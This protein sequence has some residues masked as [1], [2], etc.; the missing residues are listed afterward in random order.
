MS[1]ATVKERGVLF[2][3][4]MVRAVLEGRK[5]QTRRIVKDLSYVDDEGN[6]IQ[7]PTPDQWYPEALQYC[8]YGYIGDR[9]WVRET[10]CQ[11]VDPDTSRPY[12]PPRAHY[13]SDGNEV[14]LDDGDG[15]TAYREDG[16]ECSPWKA[17]IHMP[18][19]ASRILLEVTAVGVERV[20]DISERDAVAEGIGRSGVG[21]KN[22]G[23]DPQVMFCNPVNS[24]ISLW[25]S[26]NAAK[27]YGWDA[28]PWVWV[29]EFKVL[30]VKR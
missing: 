10:W 7:R 6:T 12:D 20:Q 19:W 3:G 16:T 27:G 22:Y 1:A 23:V 28:N 13:R 29:V 11:A 30:E 8:P 26:I 18:R 21:W 9:L 2:N 4:E 25:D 14:Y 15:F 24:F 5:T 17:S